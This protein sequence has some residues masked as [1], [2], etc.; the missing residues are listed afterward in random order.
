MITTG[1]L[2]YGDE[3]R[4]L[5]F[6]DEEHP[7]AVQL[8][9]SD[10]SDLAKSA[11]RCEA[12][13]YDEINL[14]IGCPSER[15]Q[16]GA[17]GACLMNEPNLVADCI[18]AM[19]D[20]VTIPVTIKCRIGVDNNDSYESLSDFVSINQQAGCDVFII[21]AR[22][23]WLSGLSPKQN[24]EIPP[25]NYDMV[26]QIKKD[27]PDLTI[28]LNGGITTIEQCEDALNHIDGVMMGREAYHNP[29]LLNEIDQRLY[30]TTEPATSTT[31][32]H[33]VHPLDIAKAFTPYIEQELANGAKL[34]HLTRHIL[35]LFNGRP[36]AKAWRRYLSEN[37]HKADA[38]IDTYL[39]S[40]A[41]FES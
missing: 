27:L 38:D 23:A 17:F 33:A 29:F 13:G 26:Y 9:G 12:F 20:V 24:R 3:E 14:N 11:K 22:K 8:G 30:G 18:K 19:R 34:N 21:H 15:V 7:I 5:R 4:H 31:V 10:P 37:A 16:N 32:N 39:A 6:N 1:A 36:K 41:I 2:L 40:L 25:L 28:I 35:G